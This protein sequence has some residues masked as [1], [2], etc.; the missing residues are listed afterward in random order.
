MHLTDNEAAIRAADREN[1][2]SRRKHNNRIL[3][4]VVAGLM[5]VAAIYYLVPHWGM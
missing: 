4:A 5:V 3:N 2:Y 1:Q